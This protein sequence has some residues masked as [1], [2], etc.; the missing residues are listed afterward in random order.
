MTIPYDDPVWSSHIMILCK[1]ANQYIKNFRLFC[2]AQ[3]QLQQQQLQQQQMQERRHLP[4]REGV[5]GEGKWE[6]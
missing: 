4:W 5:Q 1:I 3:A 2:Q 6:P